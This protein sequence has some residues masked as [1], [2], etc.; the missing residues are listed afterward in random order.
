M[1]AA[2]THFE[3]RIAGLQFRQD[4]FDDDRIDHAGRSNRGVEP[5][6]HGGDLTAIAAEQAGGDPAFAQI[7]NAGKGNAV[8]CW[9]R[10]HTIHEVAERPAF[11]CR[12]LN[13]DAEISAVALQTDGLDA[14]QSGPN[15]ARQILNRQAV[16]TRFGFQ[17]QLIIDLPARIVVADV[18]QSRNVLKRN[19]QI[20]DRRAHLIAI[21]QGQLDG[22]RVAGADQFGGDHDV[23]RTGDATDFLAPGG[24]E[25]RVRPCAVCHIGELDF[26]LGQG[27]TARCAPT[28]RSTAAR[29]LSD[30]DIDAVDGGHRLTRIGRLDLRAG[31]LC[32]N[33]R[34]RLPPTPSGRRAC[35]RSF[36]RGL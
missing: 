1:L 27:R 23:F 21:G 19:T 2:E 31:P 13:D 17:S 36:R 20:A 35:L 8:A 11:A 34:A 32:S 12:V 9:R 6:R 22:N 33:N 29:A 16:K 18:E 10:Y 7:G 14:R 3:A 25:D 4:V 28:S 24:F 15:L 30:N 5:G 26:H